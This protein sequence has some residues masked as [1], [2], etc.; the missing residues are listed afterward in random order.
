MKIGSAETSGPRRTRSA[1]ISVAHLSLSCK[2]ASVGVQVASSGDPLRMTKRQL[3]LFEEFP[4]GQRLSPG[5][6]IRWLPQTRL[7]SRLM[8]HREAEA[9]CRAQELDPGRRHASC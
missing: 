2:E 7:R 9:P 1:G 5:L 6:A 3:K 8:L 4:R